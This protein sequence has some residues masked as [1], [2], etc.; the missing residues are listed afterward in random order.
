MTAPSSR[1]VLLLTADRVGPAMAGPA[2]RAWELGRVLAADGHRV[3]LATPELDP[4]GPPS[5]GPGAGGDGV[6]VVVAWGDELRPLVAA[7]EV[8]VAMTGV[9]AG[10]PWLATL[11][12]DALPSPTAAPPRSSAAT[13]G[14]PLVV[15]DAYDP[16]LFE[17]LAGFDGEAEPTRSAR[18]ADATRS[19]CAPLDWV[20]FVLC[21]SSAQRH[22]LLGVL[23]GGGRL[24]AAAWADDPRLDS[25]VALVPFGVPSS[26]P[27]RR[28]P[29]GGPLRGPDGPFGLDDLVLLWGGGLWDWLDPPTL[30]RAVHAVGDPRVRVCFLAGA[31]PTA[32]VAPPAMAGAARSLAAE[33]G[34][35]AAGTGQVVFAEAWVPYDERAAWL[36][37]ADVGVSLAPGHVEST[38]AHR[39]R[40][41][42]YLW[43]G[44]PV[45]HSADPGEPDDLA[46]L[47]DA[48]GAGVVVAPGDVA[49]LAAA[50]G[51]L[52]EPRWYAE[53]S[54]G[55]TEAAAGRTWPV[56]ARP[57]RDF[58]RAP[59]TTLSAPPPTPASQPA[60]G[61][62]ARRGLAG[63][64]RR[65]GR[66]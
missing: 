45:L 16:V 43:A 60:R 44:L 52:A 5:G 9:L 6:E 66:T 63:V 30:L 13:T 17:V 40:V 10:L 34:L 18:I 1:P 48:H 55:A 57:L 56:V 32:T 15:A 46:R 35:D 26:P 53:A 62:V 31:H 23:A 36:A 50:I 51:R 7:S 25:A 3:T 42:D 4:A 41:L 37:D 2:I 58:C 20:D 19:M 11:G 49:G 27:P 38:F 29:G 21:A 24:G 64:R 54:L 65:L 59:R 61:G 12:G 33:L 39:T 8:V 14:R 28:P 22:L 47:I